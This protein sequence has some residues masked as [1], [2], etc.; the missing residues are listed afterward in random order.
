MRN[1]LLS[2]G[3]VFAAAGIMPA[4][5]ITGELRLSVADTTGGGLHVTGTITNRAAGIDREFETDDT[6][7]VILRARPLGRYD[8]TA[9]REG[10]TPKTISVEIQSQLPLEQQ[11]SLDVTPL[12]T[13]VEVKDEPLV[14]PVQTA[15]YLPHQAL[16]DRAS[17]A[18][19]RA[20]IN[21]VNTQPGWVL[22]ANGTLHPRGSE[23]DVQYIVD[24]VPLYDNRSPAFAQ[25]INI[26][27]FESLNV[28]TSGY[29]AEFGL[30]LGGVIETASDQDVRP[31]LQGAA[32]VQEGSFQNRAS[33]LSLRYG[34]GRTSV[35][36]TGDAIG[37]HRYL[38]PPLEQNFTNRGTGRGFAAALERQWS[39]A[40]HTRF[41]ATTRKTRFNVPNKRMQELAGQRQ[42]RDGGETL[43]QVAH[44]HIFSLH[45]LGQFR[46]MT[47]HTDARLWSNES[48]TPIRPAQDREFY[49][50]Y[51]AGTITGH[52][53]AHELK[54]GGEVWFSSVRE[55]LTY[56]IDAYRIGTVRIFDGDV[57][58]DFQF[59]ARAPGR[60]QSAF[61]QDSWRVRAFNVNAGIRFDHYRLIANESAW[62]PR[63]GV[64]YNVPRAG[65]LLR[66]SYDRVFQIPAMENIL[67]ASSNE[68]RNLGGEG[69]FL[70][71]RPSHGN[72]VEA[73]FSKSVS[74]YVRIDGSWYR[75]SFENFADDSLLFNTGVSFPIAFR[76]ATIRG[77][78][79]KIDVRSLGPFSGHVSYSNMSGIGRLP[80]AGGLFLG[81]DVNELLNSDESFPISQDQRNTLRSQIRFQPH[82]RFWLA[83]ATSYNSGLPFEIEGPANL[84]FIA[85]QYGPRIL[86]RVN[87]NRGRVRP[88]SSLD[89]SAGVEFFHSDHARLRLQ[90]DVF[91]LW[92]RL[93]LI[94]FA[95]VFS[96]TAL[97]VPRSFS[98]RLRADF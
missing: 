19:N 36:L 34:K 67:L 62:S 52:W 78:E 74:R 89:A 84:D 46:V 71:L 35:G 44:T 9:H 51:S 18:A 2:L 6:G 81:D 91:N 53:G 63:L 21:L 26:D 68:V 87:F 98:L 64:A 8:V 86:G 79:A 16:E 65:L 37:T 72:F 13:T 7:H 82:P 80:V 96:G 56:H 70:P 41:Y 14:E 15:Q 5:R 57:P 29:P 94:N 60:I 61:V 58:R 50:T 22:E 11:L 39:A 10:F 90:A 85:Q 73:G 28:R 20:A 66:G 40:D 12:S 97:D 54:T 27:E 31:G 77:A 69:A 33:F 76:E 30:K 59:S 93:N 55:Y 43:G 25:S 42:D 75:R 32:S 4:Q 24:G 38:D 45:L 92:D 48:S 3:L 47:R 83:L 1:W 49:E 17:V 95:G 88:S 23:Y